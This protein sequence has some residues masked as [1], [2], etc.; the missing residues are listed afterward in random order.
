MGSF[1]KWIKVPNELLSNL[2]E[3]Y[4]LLQLRF[5]FGVVESGVVWVAAKARPHFITFQR[6]KRKL[7]AK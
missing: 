2:I 6:F 3:L 5:D 1:F 4:K 7:S